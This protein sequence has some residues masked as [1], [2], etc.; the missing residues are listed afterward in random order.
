ML[1]SR[2]KSGPEQAARCLLARSSRRPSS[3]E[4][5]GPPTDSC[6]YLPLADRREGSIARKGFSSII[7]FLFHLTSIRDHP[8]EAQFISF[9]VAA[10]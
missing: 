9:Q 7:S 2:L 5:H 1:Q 10:L 8:R 4:S 3:E 6:N